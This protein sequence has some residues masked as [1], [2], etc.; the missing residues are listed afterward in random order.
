MELFRPVAFTIII[1]WYFRGIVRSVHCLG[2][3]AL[4]FP[5][6]IPGSY[7]CFP[8]S[9]RCV[10]WVIVIRRLWRGT[11]SKQ[12]TVR[13]PSNPRGDVVNCFNKQ[14]NRHGF[15]AGEQSWKTI[16]LSRSPSRPSFPR[17]VHNARKKFTHPMSFH[18]YLY[19]AKGTNVEQF[20]F[21]QGE[22]GGEAL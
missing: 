10:L 15:V 4:V 1:R 21:F 5:A 12:A 7:C 19:A 6:L 9:A 14:T 16:I 20:F 11:A 8:T 18:Q 22:T 17:K 2:S 13:D 3:S